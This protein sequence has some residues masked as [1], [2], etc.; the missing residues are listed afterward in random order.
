MK[1]LVNGKVYIGQSIDIAARRQKHF[2]SL[3]N[4][5]HSNRHLQST[6]NLYGVSAF[7]FTILELCDEVE[8]NKKE[9]YYIQL[10][11]SLSRANGFNIRAEENAYSK[12]SAETLEIMKSAKARHS[13]EVYAYTIDGCL[14]G[15]W[16]SVSAC[17][18][19]LI[20]NP[21]DV[22]RT[23]SQKQRL[24]RGLVLNNEPVFRLRQNKRMS[25][26]KNLINYI[27]N[28]KRN[29]ENSNNY[30]LI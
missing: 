29:K 5:K 25:N 23:I 13:K 30:S 6:F 28:N 7:K 14:V 1:C 24:C 22:R 16:D 20:V 10:F 15:H 3:K 12:H 18:K 19:D 9:A 4:N 21:C 11:S 26:Y 2:S 27:E 8:L 17:A